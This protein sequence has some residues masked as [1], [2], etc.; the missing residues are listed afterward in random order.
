MR[1]MNNEEI[2]REVSVLAP[3]KKKDGQVYIF[4][5]K[6]SK[7]VERYPGYFGFFG[8]GVEEGETIEEALLREIKEELDIVLDRFEYFDKYYLPKTI[9]DVFTTEVGDNFENEITVLEGDYGQWFNED[10][11]E[12]QREIITGNLKIL[13]DLYAKLK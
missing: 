10:D 4:L 3:Y 9:V 2:K 7:D 5:Q 12:T 6:R 11:F 1:H 8:G 13:E